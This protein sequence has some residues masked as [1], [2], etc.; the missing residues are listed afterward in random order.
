MISLLYFVVA[1]VILAL[2]IQAFIAD[3]DDPARQAFLAFAAAVAIAYAAFA[4]SLLPTLGAI[5]PLYQLAGGL[6]PAHYI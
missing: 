3:R 1:V 4:L 5:R 2:A 6:A